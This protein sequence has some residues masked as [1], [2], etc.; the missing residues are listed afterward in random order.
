MPRPPQSRGFTVIEMVVAVAILA[1]LVA[2][3]RPLLE[4]Q[5]QRA[6]EQALREALRTI[7]S[8]LDEHKRL[9]DSGRLVAPSSASG[10]PATLDVLVDGVELADPASGS[11]RRL[12]LLRRLPRDPFA[13]PT[14]P[15][16]STWRVRSHDSAADDPQPGGDVFDVMSASD[17]RALDGSRVA[18]W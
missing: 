2:A 9:A 17:R 12:H 5:Q 6:R 14:L 7:R 15:A 11:T 13:D 18:D 1:V 16:A 4:V 10:W 3:A 8:A